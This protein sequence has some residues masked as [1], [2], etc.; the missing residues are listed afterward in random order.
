[1]VYAGQTPLGRGA[2]GTGRVTVCR[3]HASREGR[4]GPGRV[5][6][7]SGEDG[8]LVSTEEDG[9]TFTIRPLHVFY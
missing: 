5:D 6:L 3:A 7:R 9:F 4:G 8:P 1:M 2:P